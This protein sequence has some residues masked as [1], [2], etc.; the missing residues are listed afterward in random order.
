M[1]LQHSLKQIY[2]KKLAIPV[3]LLDFLQNTSSPQD[4]K[5]FPA[6]GLEAKTHPNPHLLYYSFPSFVCTLFRCLPLAFKASCNP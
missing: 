1:K 5:N 4:I 2:C 3:A 6:K